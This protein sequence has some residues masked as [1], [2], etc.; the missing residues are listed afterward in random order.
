MAKKHERQRSS[1]D[2][3]DSCRKRTH[4]FLKTRTVE[5]II[6]M[7]T[8]V[9]LGCVGL[10]MGI[11]HNWFCFGKE[12]L[13]AYDPTAA[14]ATAD[15]HHRLLGDAHAPDAHATDAHGTDAHG[16]GDHG[17]HH[18]AITAETH[19]ICETKDGHV[20][21][22][23]HHNAHMLSIFILSTFLLELL[24]KL[25][26]EP[27]EF[28]GDWLHMLE[29]FIV[30]ISLAVDIFLTTDHPWTEAVT[31]LLFV[32]A[33]RLVRVVHAV[34]SEWYAEHEYT[35]EMAEHIEKLVKI[36][37]G[38][39]VKI[40]SDLREPPESPFPAMD[41]PC[42]RPCFA[43]CGFMPKNKEESSEEEAE[44]DEEELIAY[45]A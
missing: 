33:W 17:D 7:L 29:L 2:D 1:E 19:H 44:E 25:A 10:E 12:P 6:L 31:L 32:R 21:H 14:A 34:F 11:D 15:A 30:S 39:G 38:S 16:A 24:V 28:C 40:P 20:S 37:D 26:C 42:A 36:C 3:D 9:D 27:A 43:L 35:E 23:I 45:G 13:D 41:G 22:H 18:H 8:L 5:Y 4:W